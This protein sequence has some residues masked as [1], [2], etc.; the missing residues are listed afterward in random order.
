MSIAVRCCV[1]VCFVRVSFVLTIGHKMSPSTSTSS[2]IFCCVFNLCV[3]TFVARCVGGTPANICQ[4]NVSSCWVLSNVYLPTRT[5]DGHHLLL[6]S[7]FICNHRRWLLYC[8]SM[9][10]SMVDYCSYSVAGRA[11]VWQNTAP[12]VLWHSDRSTYLPCH[13]TYNTY[14]RQTVND[15]SISVSNFPTLLYPWEIEHPYL[16]TGVT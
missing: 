14:S 15:E 2:D 7:D 5:P 10:V 16:S 3:S 6:I 13:R 1:L 12:S 11:G 8:E 9:D 4:K